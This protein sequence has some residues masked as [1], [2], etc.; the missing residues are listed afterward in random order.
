MELGRCFG[1]GLTQLDLTAALDL[2]DEGFKALVAYSWELRQLSL[3]LCNSLSPA[4]LRQLPLMPHLHT[5][6]L[7][8]RTAT[9][10]IIIRDSFFRIK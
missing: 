4:S 7:Q 1:G 2:Q 3:H 9:L 8:A 5:L 6:N 10:S